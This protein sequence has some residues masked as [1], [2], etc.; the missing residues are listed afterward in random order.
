[1]GKSE[2]ALLRYIIVKFHSKYYNKHPK[3]ETNT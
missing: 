3:Q 2:W 1:M